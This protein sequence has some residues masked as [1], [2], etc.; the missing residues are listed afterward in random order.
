MMEKKQGITMSETTSK[1]GRKEILTKDLAGKICKMI[2]RMPDADIPVTWENVIAH[3][4]K[5]FGQGFN[6][7]MLSQKTWDG[8]KLISEA[9]DLAKETQRRKQHD[10]APKYKTAPRSIMQK[11]IADLEAKVL[12]LTEEL[13]AERS[14]KINDLDAVL[15]TRF[16]LRVL[17]E[18]SS[19]GK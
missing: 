16:D 14:R 8:R 4:K 18:E 12:A 6:R 19:K 15:N 17:L 1:L 7:Q 5:R 3:S 13:E 9:F 10:S 11:R 2:E